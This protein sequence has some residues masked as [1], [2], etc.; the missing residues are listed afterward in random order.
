LWGLSSSTTRHLRQWVISWKDNHPDEDTSLTHFRWDVPQYWSSVHAVRLLRV[1]LAAPMQVLCLDG[2]PSDMASISTIKLLLDLC[3]NLK[4]LTL[5][6]RAS[7]NQYL[8]SP[9]VWKEPLWQY[10]S[11]VGSFPFLEHFEWN[12]SV[13]IQQP[14][15]A[16]LLHMEEHELDGTFA[17]DGNSYLCTD[18]LDFDDYRLNAAP[19]FAYSSSL[20]TWVANRGS[21]IAGEEIVCE[22]KR[23]K[24]TRASPLDIACLHKLQRPHLAVWDIDTET[25]YPTW[26]NMPNT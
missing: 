16:P 23:V 10:A 18:P 19:F 24:D 17:T 6:V 11:L 14:T 3:P 1:I 8:P 4:A 12:Y 26:P 2:L 15:L 25:L 20:N 9:W 13:P 21:Q 22:R 5:T 7:T